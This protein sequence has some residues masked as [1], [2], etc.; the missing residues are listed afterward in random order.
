ME[1][2]V[3]CGGW[4]GQRA[5]IVLILT[6]RL[7][8]KEKVIELLEMLPAV[9]RYLIICLSLYCREHASTH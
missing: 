1:N 9:E 2:W 5:L 6:R 3:G 8:S 7:L 4:E